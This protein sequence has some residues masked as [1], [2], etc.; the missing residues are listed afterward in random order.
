MKKVR[1]RHGSLD[2]SSVLIISA[3]LLLVLAGFKKDPPVRRDPPPPVATAAPGACALVDGAPRDPIAKALLPSRSGA[4]CLDPHG[5]E[6]AYGEDSDRPY[7]RACDELLDGEC[8]VYK[9]FGALRTLEV[10]YIDDAGG[11]RTMVVHLTKFM[12][13]EGA[14][15][16]FTLRVV[17]DGDPARDASQRPIEAKF[18]AAAGDNNA[19]VVRG[20]YLAEIVFID[21]TAG[22][23]AALR[24]AAAPLVVPLAK[25]IGAKLTGDSAPPPAAAALPTASRVPLG[26]RYHTRDMFG[27]AGA[28][29]GAV[30]YY[31]EGDKRYRVAA[32]LRNDADQAKDLLATFARQAGASREKAPYEG[33]VR[34]VLQAPGDAPAEWVFGRARGVVLGIGDEVR[35]IEP[36]MTS[37]DRDKVLLLAKEKMDK[38]KAML[39]EKSR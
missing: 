23:V 24:S 4:F 29:P 5:G 14:F 3:A 8:E 38:L 37:A 1:T 26:V 17:G 34:V 10:R 27:I 18:A 25:E 11:S 13:A 32:L 2:K 35:V 20:P 39:E 16:M 36:T 15:A 33:F 21:D 9:S 7:E 28:G 6:R 19:Y 22:S 12:T 31:R 30:G